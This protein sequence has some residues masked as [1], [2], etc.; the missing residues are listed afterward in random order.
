MKAQNLKKRYCFHCS[1]KVKGLWRKASEKEKIFCSVEC[2]ETN[3]FVYRSSLASMFS[4]FNEKFWMFK[5]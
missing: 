2:L 1:E 3:N 4:A 5:K